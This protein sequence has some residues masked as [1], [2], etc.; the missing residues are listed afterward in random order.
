MVAEK[1]AARLDAA[2]LIRPADHKNFEYGAVL[3]A[4]S[5]KDAKRIV[6]CVNACAGISNEVLEECGKDFLANYT[7]QLHVEKLAEQRDELL[8]ALKE[9]VLAI[10]VGGGNDKD[11]TIKAIRQA[12][13]NARA[14]IQKVEA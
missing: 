8:A 4:T 7:D 3:A 2:Y 10:A 1:A 11:S 13:N 14:A 6:A 5:E 9:Y 12:D